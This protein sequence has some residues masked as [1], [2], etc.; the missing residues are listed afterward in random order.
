MWKLCLGLAAIYP[1]GWLL[2]WDITS[3]S[4][5]AVVVLTICGIGSYFDDRRPS[6]GSTIE[7]GGPPDWR[8]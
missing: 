6:G 2:G 7:R 8:D 5:S 3:E 4:V 1:A